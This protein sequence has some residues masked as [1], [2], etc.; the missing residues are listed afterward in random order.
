MEASEQNNQNVINNAIAEYEK[1]HGL[2]DG[3]PIEGKGKKGKKNKTVVDDDDDDVD[4]D[5][6]DLPPAFKRCF[7]PSKSKSRP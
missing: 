6:D 7:K 4:D 1:K 3:K 5:L 2:K